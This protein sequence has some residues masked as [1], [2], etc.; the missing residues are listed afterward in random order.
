MHKHELLRRFL[1]SLAITAIFAGSSRVALAAG[2]SDTAGTNYE[3]A[4]SYLQEKGIVAGYSD[5]LARPTYP[6]N[7]V[8][9]LK[10]ILESYGKYDKTISAYKK[11]MPP[12]PLF[13]D[14]DQKQ[15][16]APY[17][18]TAFENGVITGYPDG[19]VRPAKLLTVEEAV[20]MLM[21]T[22][23]EKGSS[24][25]AE[26]SAY[27]QNQPGQWYTPSINVAITR[28][29]VMHAGQR[30]LGAVITR[31]EFFDMVYRLHWI[32]S[33]GEVAYNGR[34]PNE[35]RAVVAAPTPVYT[36]DEN[37]EPTGVTTTNGVAPRPQP[38][39]TPTPA[40]QQPVTIAPKIDHP[41]ASEK[42]FAI[43]MPSLGIENLA[44]IH[45]EDALSHDGVL[46]P[47]SNGVGHLF[48]YPGGGGKIMIY[49]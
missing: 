33:R 44:I 1:A 36:L 19:T 10:V 20:T 30:K 41:Y 24:Q 39:V 14:T 6:L 21:R 34:E 15:W 9:A 4:F 8:E 22:F 16:Y 3:I 49:G 28:N 27:M 46:A 42:Y 37:L 2:F 11:K 48:A 40:P 32:R 47:L 12:L 35:P 38:Q 13:G 31:G 17:I 26:L 29:L 45:P 7:R 5:G 23:E 25:K 18:E 43:S